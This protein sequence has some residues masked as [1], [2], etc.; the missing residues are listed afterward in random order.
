M[1]DSIKDYVQSKLQPSAR[2]SSK[3]S[4]QLNVT[5]VVKAAM[6]LQNIT[7]EHHNDDVQF[8]T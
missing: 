2:G 3:S 6:K 1:E 8:K 5:K 7:T 4:L